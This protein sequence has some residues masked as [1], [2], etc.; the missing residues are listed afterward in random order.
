M[1][2]EAIKAH[3]FCSEGCSG[4]CFKVCERSVAQ[5]PPNLQRSAAVPTQGSKF[6]RGG[7]G[8]SRGE[9]E[10]GGR[11]ARSRAAVQRTL[12]LPSEYNEHGEGP[13]PRNQKP[14][15]LHAH[16]SCLGLAPNPHPSRAHPETA[17][18]KA[19]TPNPL[20]LAFAHAPVPCMVL[21]LIPSRSCVFAPSPIIPPSP[22]VL[23]F[24][25]RVAAREQGCCLGARCGRWALVSFAS[26][27]L[28]FSFGSA[29]ASSPAKAAS[30]AR[31]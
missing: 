13:N 27:S 31:R 29:V 7:M 3:L 20:C 30:A 4:D 25:G 8:R 26:A 12:V 24:S 18:A 19:E 22:L 5:Y 28:P 16:D 6:M 17:S 21:A 14:E 23:R 15:T 10:V 11:S 9:S 2:R 1:Q